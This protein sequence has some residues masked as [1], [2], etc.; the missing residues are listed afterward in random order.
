MV[1]TNSIK[2]KSKVVVFK[3]MF[4]MFTPIPVEM[5]KTFD[6]IIFFKCVTITHRIHGTGI[7]TYINYHKNQPFM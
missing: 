4:F 6:D 7:L 2:S 3:Y 5:M 1:P